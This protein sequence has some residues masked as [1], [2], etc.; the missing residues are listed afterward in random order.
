MCSIL[1]MFKQTL[2]CSVQ[3]DLSPD[4]CVSLHGDCGIA[5]THR[6]VALTGGWQKGQTCS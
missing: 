2:G 5:Q 1:V 3:V 4:V 6:Y